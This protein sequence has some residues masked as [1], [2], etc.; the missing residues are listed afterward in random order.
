MDLKPVS[1]PQAA[2]QAPMVTPTPAPQVDPF[3]PDAPSPVKGGSG[4]SRKSR[5]GLKVFMLILL[6]LV[7]LGGVGYGTFYWQHQHVDRLIAQRGELNKE[8]AD[9]NAHMAE[10]EAENAKLTKEVPTTLT[11]DE[12]VIAAVKA[13]CEAGVDPT[14][15]KSLVYIQGTM[16]PSKKKILYSTDKKYAE[17][18]AGCA[19]TATTADGGKNY[20]LKYSDNTWVVIDSGTQANATTTKLY[21][22]PVTFN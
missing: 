16:G 9:L 15:A 13:Y 14:T 2:P 11:T 10:M 3:K 8:I 1:K 21:N 4:K 20:I 12:Q 17:V 5:G 6:V 7:L 18:N 19:A 22:I